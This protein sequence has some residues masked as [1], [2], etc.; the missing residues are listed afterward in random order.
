MKVV[1]ALIL[2]GTMLSASAAPGR[3]A[4]SEVVEQARSLLKSGQ[5]EEALAVLEDHLH[6]RIGDAETLELYGQALAKVGRNDEAA[7]SFDRALDL[8]DEKDRR[9]SSIERLLRKSDRLAAKRER[10]L[11]K[12]TDRML[13]SAERLQKDGHGERALA[14]LER[15][16]PIAETKERAEIAALAAEI[17][18]ATTEVDLEASAGGERPSGGWPLVEIEGEH[19]DVEANLEPEVAQRVADVMDDIFSYYALLYFDGDVKKAGSRKATIR[20]HRDKA[21]MLDDWTGGGNGPDGWWSPGAFE[22]HCYDSRTSTGDLEW[23]LEVLFHEASHQFMTLLEKGG[24]TPAWLNE[25]TASFFEGAVAME[26][27]RV[28]WPDAAPARLQSLVSMFGGGVENAPSFVDVISYSAQG[29]YPAEYYAWGW[30]LAFFLQQFEDPETLAYVYRPLYAEYR[31][32]IIKRSGTSPRELF[33][34][35]FLGEGSPLGHETLAEFEATWRDWI[36]DEVYL[37]HFGREARDIRTERVERYL[38]AAD[39]AAKKRKA[40]VSEEDL[41]LRALGQI[42]FVRTSIDDAQRPDAE[43]LLTQADVLE[44]LDRAASAAPLLEQVLGMA[45]AGELELEDKELVELEQRLSRIDSK[46]AALRSARGRARGLAVTARRLLDEYEDADDRLLLRSYSFAKLAGAVLDDEEHLL[47]V[48]TRLRQEALEAGLLRGAVVRMTTAAGHWKTIFNNQETAFE[49]GE[50]RIAL[51]GVRPVGK[52]CTGVPIAGEYEIRA[53]FLREGKVRRS[54]FHGVVISGT[55]G[56][57]WLII[58]ISGN[59]GGL[60]MKRLVLSGGGVVE[61]NLRSIRPTPPVRADERIELGVHVTPDGHVSVTLGDRDPVPF[62][63]PLAVPAVGHVGLYV[64]D[65]RIA[66]EDLVV[67]LLP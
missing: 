11:A 29:S 26:D 23:M 2:A 67:E 16:R 31:D 60:M 40:P 6:F 25:G 18:S 30:G 33:E 15:L 43:L 27:R 48:A 56:G 28:L 44:R 46:N 20:I 3:A 49:L 59:A 22:V 1:P 10:L 63:M 13:D 5:T 38:T 51:E 58:G 66:L 24:N 21:A 57:D 32:R 62:S 12:I 50:E 14:I 41:L 19:Y 17:R 55:A 42:E 65:G 45:A 61:V 7:H 8:L 39:R 37:P 52:I 4:C 53:R 64:K 34:D 47:P 36:K 54:S 35:V 9:A